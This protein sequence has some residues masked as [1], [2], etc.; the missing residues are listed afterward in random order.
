[1]RT[2]RAHIVWLAALLVCCGTIR[3]SP[4]AE[5]TPRE[6]VPAEDFRALMAGELAWAVDLYRKLGAAEGNL[7]FSPMSI[8]T[9]LADHPFLF[10]IRHR[11]TGSILFMGRVANPKG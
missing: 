2:L 7:T 6:K 10:L 3:V 4:A 8:R 5:E 11:P 1:M 9:A